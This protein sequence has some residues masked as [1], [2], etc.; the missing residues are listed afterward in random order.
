MGYKILYAKPEKM[1]TFFRKQVLTA[2]IFFL[3]CFLMHCFWPAG[4]EVLQYYLSS[5]H[6]S[7]NS[8]WPQMIYD[9]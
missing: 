9:S 5:K 4:R 3:T 8:A 1:D 7:V 2:A 6:S